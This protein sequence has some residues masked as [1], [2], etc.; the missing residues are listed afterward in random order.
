MGL[1]CWVKFFFV[2]KIKERKENRDDVPSWIMLQSYWRTTRF[3][4][5]R[6]CLLS[7]L[8]ECLV[9]L[10]KRNDDVEIDVKFLTIIINRQSNCGLCVTTAYLVLCLFVRL[11]FKRRYIAHSHLIVV[12]NNPFGFAFVLFNFHVFKQNVANCFSFHVMG[13][14]LS[15]TT[16]CELCE[17]AALV[18]LLTVI[19]TICCPISR[20]TPY[21]IYR[22][23]GACY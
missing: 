2:Q 8:L 11:K 6:I 3:S 4:S 7:L 13:L 16:W 18:T 23:R 15:K 20:R 19:S 12:F 10:I 9:F 22:R 21:S 17:F 1:N 5:I 14:V